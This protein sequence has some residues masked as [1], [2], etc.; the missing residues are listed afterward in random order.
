MRSEPQSWHL[1]CWSNRGTANPQ[2]SYVRKVTVAVKA[3]FSQ[4]CWNLY[5]KAF[6]YSPWFQ[7]QL[8][9]E[10]CIFPKKNSELS[11]SCSI[12]SSSIKSSKPRPK[13]SSGQQ[14]ECKCLHEETYEK[15]IW[16]SIHITF[17]YPPDLESTEEKKHSED[18]W[19]RWEASVS[20]VRFQPI[21]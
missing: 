4:V 5:L 6:C 2:T 13:R 8:S 16:S 1:S 12:K 15:N 17:W 19:N 20:P 10:N 21:F 3:T 7:R 18:R 9:E 14:L 11:G